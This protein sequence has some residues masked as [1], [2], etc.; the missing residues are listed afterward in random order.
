MIS[1]ENWGDALSGD[2]ARVEQAINHF[3]AQGEIGQLLA[4]KTLQH[5]Y[6]DDS[7]AQALLDMGRKHSAN[8][9]SPQFPQEI[10]RLRNLTILDLTLIDEVNVPDFAA[11]LPHLTHLSINGAHISEIQI[12]WNQLPDLEAL[13]ISFT[14]L[15]YLREGLA[16]CPHL[17]QLAITFSDMRFCPSGISNV[18]HL[19][20]LGNRNLVELPNESGLL[21][22]CEWLILRGTGVS[23]LPE[24]PNM[25][26][27]LKMLDLSETMVETLPDSAAQWGN[28]LNIDLRNSRLSSL[29]K[30]LLSSKSIVCILLQG[31]PL[32]RLLKGGIPQDEVAKSVRTKEKLLYHQ[33]SKLF[34]IEL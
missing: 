2:E 20:L 19:N 18:K 7:L 23:L 1:D 16:S 31:T 12:D 32:A 8:F 11:F 5:A 22:R 28:G 25:F 4:Y 21:D 17:E 27:S 13:T 24:N 33:L 3:A 26:P 30:S 10:L 15:Q 9:T 34:K 6:R 29:P 14:K